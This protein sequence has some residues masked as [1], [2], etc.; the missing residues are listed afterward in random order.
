MIDGTLLIVA[1]LL[2]ALLVSFFFSGS[3]TAVVSANRYRLA[4]L[5]KQGNLRAERTLALL[6]RSPRLLSAVLIGTN[7]GNVFAVLLFKTL[8]DRFWDRAAEPAIGFIRWD[9][10]ISLLA[11]TPTLVIFAEILPK[12][13]F[14]ARADAWILNLRAPLALVTLLFLPVILVLEALVNLVLIPIR[15]GKALPRRRLTRADLILMLHGTGQ[16]DELDQ[17][18]TEDR[19]LPNGAG[20]GRPS[21]RPADQPDLIREPDER[22]LIQNIIALEQTYVREVMQPLVEIEAVRLGQTTVE[23]FRDRAR[24]SGYSRFP[25]FRNRI[26]NLIGYIDV[27]DVI[28]DTEGRNDLESF[29]HPAYYVPETKRLDDLL[30]E[31]LLLRI[32]NAIVVDEYGG[33][34]GWITRED[35]IEEIVGELDDEL[36]E[37]STQIADLGDGAYRVDGRID[38]EELNEMF[39]LSLDDTECDTLGGLIMMELDRIP[40]P[41]DAVRLEGWMMTV[42]EMEGHRVAWV[43]MRPLDA[44]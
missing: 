10:L 1:A 37:P 14:R 38:L 19:A 20:N 35:I 34:S 29:V 13:L 26:T 23:A 36:D 30:R 25:V 31:F 33:C 8:L 42:I 21:P 40:A 22:R 11:F 7:L 15:R 5:R 17:F 4:H 18:E 44:A 43:E 2:A 12:A 39:S 28:R 9:E 6:A 27:Y 32:N 16:A 24:R 41:G 3:E